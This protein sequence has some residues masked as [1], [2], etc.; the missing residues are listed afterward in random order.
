MF[1]FVQR[2]RWLALNP[3]LFLAE[4]TCP[5]K[6][7]GL[8][9][10]RPSVSWFW[11]APQPLPFPPLL[12]EH[13]SFLAGQGFD[14]GPGSVSKQGSQRELLSQGPYLPGLVPAALAAGLCQ[15]EHNEQSWPLPA[16]CSLGEAPGFSPARERMITRETLTAVLERPKE[17]GGGRKKHFSQTWKTK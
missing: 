2:E 3:V 11:R 6:S 1:L 7:L 17:E 14:F 4:A 15:G 10:L 16:R 13:S 9:F 12:Q 5:A 8:I